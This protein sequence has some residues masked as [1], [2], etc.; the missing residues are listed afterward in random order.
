LLPAILRSLG[1]LLVFASCS[2]S[3]ASAQQNHQAARP[4]V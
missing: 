1:G 2:A 3:S 4:P